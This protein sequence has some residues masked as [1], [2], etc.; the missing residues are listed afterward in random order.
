MEA[1]DPW[2]GGCNWL[3]ESDD[4][5]MGM[6]GHRGTE[7]NVMDLRCVLEVRKPGLCQSFD[8]VMR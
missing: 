6:S 5:G 3:G 2:G 1:R 7:E 4:G 8:E